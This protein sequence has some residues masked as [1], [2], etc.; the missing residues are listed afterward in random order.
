MTAAA[1]A[2][3]SRHLATRCSE[4]P[5]AQTPIASRAMQIHIRIY[6]RRV[7]LACIVHCA[8]CCVCVCVCVCVCTHKAVLLLLLLLRAADARWV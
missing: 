7:T 4:P 8:V 1:A 3:S 2:A 5:R 6:P